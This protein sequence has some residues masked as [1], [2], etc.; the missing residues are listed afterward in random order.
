MNIYYVRSSIRVFR[1]DWILFECQTWHI[2]SA[3]CKRIHLPFFF[4][5]YSTRFSNLY[6]ISSNK[7]RHDNKNT[8]NKMELNVAFEQ[9]DAPTNKQRTKPNSRNI[10]ISTRIWFLKSLKS[11]GQTHMEMQ[12]KCSLYIVYKCGTRVLFNIV[13][14]FAVHTSFKIE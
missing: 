10:K 6:V 4:F 9:R 13:P 7:E 14:C 2:I 8:S 12:I 5:F 1:L 3:C 11:N